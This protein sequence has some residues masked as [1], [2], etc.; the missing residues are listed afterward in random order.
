ML[1]SPQNTAGVWNVPK[2][3]CRQVTG[4]NDM[5]DERVG[6][7]VPCLTEQINCGTTLGEQKRCAGAVQRE[8][9]ALMKGQTTPS[10]SERMSQSPPTPGMKHSH[11]PTRAFTHEH[12]ERHPRN[13]FTQLTSVHRGPI[14]DF[15]C[16]A[17]LIAAASSHRTQLLISFLPPSLVFD[18]LSLFAV[19]GVLSVVKSSR[20]AQWLLSVVQIMRVLFFLF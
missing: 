6:G 17:Y 7:K 9:K 14:L 2:R 15:S 8:Y 10:W 5:I 4:Q 19:P 11:A 1:K 13:H 20:M 18:F 12:T 3:S 16:K